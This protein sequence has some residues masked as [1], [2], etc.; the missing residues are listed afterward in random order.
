MQHRGE[1][2]QAFTWR[3]KGGWLSWTFL[4][5]AFTPSS[6]RNVQVEGD[7][8]VAFALSLCSRTMGESRD[9]ASSQQAVGGVGG[10]AAGK[11]G[12]LHVIG[13]GDGDDR[14]A[15]GLDEEE[16]GPESDEG[17]ESPEGLEDAGVAG[18]RLLN[19]GA[20][21]PSCTSTQ[22][23]RRCCCPWVVSHSPHEGSV[24][25]GRKGPPWSADIPAH[26]SRVR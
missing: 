25:A 8:G 14:L 9:A 19:G 18:S 24:A 4:E 12:L 11:E 20:E 1:F 7:R 3:G 23:H 6:E 26:P 13:K 17:E 2:I 5:P 15:D 10:E 16:G 21:F 22:G